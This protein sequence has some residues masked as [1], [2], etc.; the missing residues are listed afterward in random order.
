M[1][2]A[3]DCQD[4]G[5]PGVDV[6]LPC[7]VGSF[8]S[9]SGLYRCQLATVTGF[10]G[11]KKAGIATTHAHADCPTLVC[12]DVSIFYSLKMEFLPLKSCIV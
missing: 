9:S 8:P 7:L 5:R 6:M 10:L 3:V 12:F 11:V 4:I 2:L 1:P